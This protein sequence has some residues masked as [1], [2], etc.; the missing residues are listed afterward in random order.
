MRI[1][2][3][4]PDG[5]LKRELWEF[6]IFLDFGREGIRLDRYMFQTRKSTRHKNWNMQTRWQRVFKRENNIANPPL[7]ADVEKEMRQQCQNIIANLPV[8]R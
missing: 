5:D 1:E 3:I 4:R 6:G 8:E 2:I 7:P